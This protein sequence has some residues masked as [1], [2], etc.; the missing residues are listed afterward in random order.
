[1]IRL[2]LCCTFR[3]QPIKFVTTTATALA[4]TSRAS[5]LEKLGRLALANADALGQALQ[6]CSENGIGCF[7]INSQILPLK[8][9]P[10]QGYSIAELPDADEI[11]SRFRACGAFAAEHGIR[12][13]FHPDQ[14]V[15]LN[16]RK[17]EVVAASLQ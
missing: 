1:M 16:S 13:C 3:D 2:G 17:P 12:T 5:G 7:R 9:H 8:T 15:V 11:V 14:F 10:Q 6:F 4:R